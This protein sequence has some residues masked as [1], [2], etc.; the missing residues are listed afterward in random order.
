MIEFIQGFVLGAISMFITIVYYVAKELPSDPLF[1]E[2][3][4]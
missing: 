1:P 3:K 4:K 2:V